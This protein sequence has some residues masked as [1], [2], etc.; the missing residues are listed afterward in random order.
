MIMIRYDITGLP[1]KSVDAGSIRRCVRAFSATAGIGAGKSF[2]LAF[3]DARAIRKF[4]RLYRGK[5]KVTDVLS[6]AQRDSEFVGPEEEGD[7]GE[8]LICLP[9]A[10]IQAKQFGWDLDREV[11]RL[12][13]HGLAHLIGYE[14]EGVSRREEEKMI[15]FEKAVMDKLK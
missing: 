9:Q 13:V 7:L 15:R 1:D 6:F 10:R 2:S 4:N 11:S 14:H 3:V 5:D 8:I 12:L